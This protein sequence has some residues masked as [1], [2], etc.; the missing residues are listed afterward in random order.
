MHAP[1]LPYGAVSSLRMIRAAL[2]AGVHVCRG[3][4]F[5]YNG[6]VYA[7]GTKLR[8]LQDRR[9]KL[10]DSIREQLEEI[11]KIKATLKPKTIAQS[12]TEKMIAIKASPKQ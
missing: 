10:P 8:R 9:K 7:V 5:E 4:N 3:V 6:T 2:T 12:K 1:I 11:E